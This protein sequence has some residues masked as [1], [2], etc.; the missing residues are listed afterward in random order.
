MECAHAG[1]AGLLLHF[2][3]MPSVPRDL[4]AALVGWKCTAF[5]AWRGLHPQHLQARQMVCP[6]T[7]V[8][9]CSYTVKNTICQGAMRE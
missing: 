8:E 5:P 6:C 3:A 2:A 4:S 9:S 7:A 1:Y